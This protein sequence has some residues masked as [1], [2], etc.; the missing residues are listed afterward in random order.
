MTLRAL[1]AQYLISPRLDLNP[2]PQN[3]P[4]IDPKW[5]VL[6]PRFRPL[7]V[8]NPEVQPFSYLNDSNKEDGKPEKPRVFGSFIGAKL[9]SKRTPNRSKMGPN[10][11]PF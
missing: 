5:V 6:D 4:E 7:A 10:L 11:D 1:G 3:D 9:G 8:S 2:D